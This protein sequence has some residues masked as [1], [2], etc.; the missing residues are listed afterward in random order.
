MSEI[1]STLIVNLLRLPALPPQFWNMQAWTIQPPPQH[2][3]MPI[4][5]VLS[6]ITFSERSH[7]CHIE[8]AAAYFVRYGKGAFGVYCV[9]LHTPR[10]SQTGQLAAGNIGQREFVGASR[11]T[12]ERNVF[13]VRTKK[14]TPGYAKLVSSTPHN[15]WMV[16]A[17]QSASGS[18]SATRPTTLG[19]G[20]TW[21]RLCG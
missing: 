3:A 5:V 20:T 21:S 1:T 19:Q 2:M 17:G 6:L 14:N 9:T 13:A 8:Q 4:C 15:L 12:E 7:F 16:S 10:C 18:I 11:A